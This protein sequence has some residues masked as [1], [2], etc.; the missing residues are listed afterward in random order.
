VRIPY[1]WW[2]LVPPKLFTRFRMRED[3]DLRA[4]EN[5]MYYIDCGH[6]EN[7]ETFWESGVKDVERLVLRGVE[8]GPGAAVLEI[9]CGMGRLLRPFVG[10]ASRVIGFDISGEMIARAQASLPAVEQVELYETDGCLKP[11]ADA[12]VDFVYSFIVFQHIPV[13]AAICRYVRE[14]RRVLR[15]GGLLRFQIDGRAP[16]DRVRLDSWNGVRWR[17]DELEDL[18]RAA[19]LRVLEITAAGT[20]YTWVTA[21]REP[22]GNPNVRH[23]PKAWRADAVEALA[24]RLG[25]EA[26]AGARVV[27]GQTTVRDLAGPFLKTSKGMKPEAYIAAAYELFLGRPADAEGL[28][29]YAG[30]IESGIDRGNVVDCLIS[31]EEFDDRYRV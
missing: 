28:R 21:I 27:A 2:R 25:L 6:G 14:A 11:V 10:R 30:E 19:G 22:E 9:G 23:R 26:G 16:D 20:Q 29:F 7:S 18:I 12:T 31:S 1:A 15:R 4:R 8:L 3:W 17:D 5:A 24:G 13:K